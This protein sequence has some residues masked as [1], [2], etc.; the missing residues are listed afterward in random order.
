MSFSE[1]RNGVIKAYIFAEKYAVFVLQGMIDSTIWRVNDKSSACF[2]SLS[3]N[4][5]IYIS[6]FIAHGNAI[7]RYITTRSK[8]VFI[9]K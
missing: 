2:P 1:Q 5:I 9:F 6:A 3:G 7:L 4:Y 8:L